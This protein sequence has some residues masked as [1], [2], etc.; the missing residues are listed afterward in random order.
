M[1]EQS[2][3]IKL[4]NETFTSDIPIEADGK[5]HRYTMPFNDGKPAYTQYTSEYQAE[6]MLADFKL[7]LKNKPQAKI[8]ITYSANE[9]QAEQ[10]IEGYGKNTD[11]SNILAGG[12]NQAEVFHELIALLQQ[13]PELKNHIHILPIATMPAGD[14]AQPASE[15][16]VKKY[17][18]N[19]AKHLGA[20]WTVLGLCNQHTPANSYAIGGGVATGWK[21]STQKELCD[22]ALNFMTANSLTADIQLTD[23]EN[24][25]S[26]KK[27]FAEGQQHP[28]SLLIPLLDQTQENFP[29]ATE[30]TV[31]VNSEFMEKVDIKDLEELAKSSNTNF[32]AE[33]DPEK[34][35][36]GYKGTISENNEDLMHITNKGL[37]CPE[38][39]NKKKQAEIIALAL[40]L[41]KTKN[42]IPNDQPL[43]VKVN[44]FSAGDLAIIIKALK[45]QNIKIQFDIT[46]E[47]DREIREL[48]TK[49]GVLYDNTN[50]AASKE[51]VLPA[52]KAAS[53]TTTGQP[54]EEYDLVDIPGDGNCL[55]ASI[56]HQLNTRGVNT[57]KLNTQSLRE[58]IADYI[59][60]HW[61][62]GE[63]GIIFKNFIEEE[64]Q[65]EA[66]IEPPKDLKDFP[67]EDK[68]KYINH[69]KTDKIWGNQASIIAASKILNINI[70]I[71]TKEGGAHNLTFAAPNNPQERPTIY[72]WHQPEVHYSSYFAK[73]DPCNPN[74]K[75]KKRSTP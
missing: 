66:G 67:L 64:D 29:P 60:K 10:L 46:G 3:T 34:I 73:N 16:N 52:L 62:G 25:K 26:L 38:V 53:P 4:K 44:N 20:G 36:Q 5:I 2:K 30:P 23:D 57:S 9:T 49:E 69:I 74:N 51:S 18:A 71:K 15:E 75:S 41:I 22:K 61:D 33:T 27:A 37:I 35:K 6:K 31:G 12:A 21:N 7:L 45:K 24:T 72:L 65:R 42:N 11:Q 17:M 59:S 50:P 40:K 32:K 8:A 56:I 70:A 55:F 47:T 28:D 54:E 58:Q 39:K 43:V 68:Q 14:G 48:I 19:I 13:E 1:P 63:D